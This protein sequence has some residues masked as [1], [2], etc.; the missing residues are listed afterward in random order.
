MDLGRKSSGTILTSS[1]QFP[2]GTYEYFNPSAATGEAHFYMECSNKGICD[3][4][5]GTCSCFD[6]YEGAGCQRTVCPS[7]CNGHGTCES[8][9]EIASKAGGT[10]FG[11]TTPVGKVKYDLWDA[12]LRYGCRCD[13]WFFGPDCSK[14][15][16]K[17]GVDPLYRS[18]GVPIYETFI[19]HG[20]SADPFAAAKI[21]LRM[22]DYYGESYVTKKIDVTDEGA[23]ANTDAA[24]L[25]AAN[26][27][28][29]IKEL[30]NGTFKDVTCEA[31]GSSTGTLK[32]KSAKVG[33][34]GFAVICQF[35]SNPGVLRLPEVA[36]TSTTGT[37]KVVN[38]V[39]RGQDDDWHTA[40]LTK[41]AP[42]TLTTAAGV[43][44][45]TITASGTTAS[46]AAA[47][48][49]TE[50]GAGPVLVKIDQYLLAVATV[51]AGSLV[52]G[53]PLDVTFSST[54][55]IFDSELTLAEAGSTVNADVN[56]G[57]DEITFLAAHGLK[58][59]DVIVY[60]HQMFTVRSV[61][62]LVVKIDRPF[63]GQLLDGTKGVATDKVYKLTEPADKSTKYTYVS[64]CSGRGLCGY[65]SGICSCFKG[66]T[67]DNCSRQNILAV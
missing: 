2:S 51:N 47:T 17:V 48:A 50:I 11:T 26:I 22:F 65:D 54:M 39:L 28:A 5:T 60:H 1:Q 15:T 67:D 24:K 31:V 56:V 35:S 53:H 4:N 63:G 23:N 34:K 6:G 25:N 59:G 32:I 62:G 45:L 29:A 13:P 44:T 19:F 33:A 40:K 64:E 30:P 58:A 52:F 36:T 8:L 43:S 18:N 66:Y 21:Q 55:S 14:R 38:T 3:R 20:G 41:L 9:E 27:A 16:C 7:K 12:K 46:G 10:L 61:N 37:F 49:I 42:N 57:D